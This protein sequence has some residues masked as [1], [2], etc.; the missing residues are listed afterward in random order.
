VTFTLL[1]SGGW[2]PSARRETCCALVR[3]GSEAILIDAGT[4]VSRLVEHPELLDGVETLEIVLTHFHLDHVAGLS[5]LPALA[6]DKRVWAAG[7][8]LY[9][10]SSESILATLLGP[11]LFASGVGA[12][13]SEVVEVGEGGM[14]I[15][16]M[17]L[18]VRAQ[19]C[20]PQPTMAL[21]AGNAWA[22]CTDTARDPG[23]AVF[24][25]GVQTLYHEAWHAA[26][27]TDDAG[28]T[29][30]GEA[31]T[32]ARDA[33]AGELVM[34]HVSPVLG[35]DEDLLA[36]ARDVFGAAAVGQDWLER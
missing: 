27:E 12:I 13:V 8:W 11:P 7:R 16:S 5:Y 9:G 29:A 30:A 15:G 34:I 35:R 6:P 4:G 3:E 31:A 18:D 33:G 17:E 26:P 25:S 21:R 32:I 20:H 24:A 36:P 10:T 22:Y 2:I 14:R 19:L 28:H 23:T 1:G